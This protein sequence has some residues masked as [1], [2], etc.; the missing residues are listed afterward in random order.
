MCPLL[1]C[2]RVCVPLGVAPGEKPKRHGHYKTAAERAEAYEQKKLRQKEARKAARP[3]PEARA[4]AYAGRER[5]RKNAWG[6]ARRAQVRLSREGGDAGGAVAAPPL[7]DVDA[8]WDE[9][10]RARVR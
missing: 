2:K 9:R 6:A 3:S 1:V 7:S 5:K 8:A 10:E 4:A